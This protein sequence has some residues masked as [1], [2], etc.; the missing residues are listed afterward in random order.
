M[1]LKPM[2]KTQLISLLCVLIIPCIPFMSGLTWFW[3]A[4]LIGLIIKGELKG[5]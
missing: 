2:S 1:K 5:K 4:A 3:L